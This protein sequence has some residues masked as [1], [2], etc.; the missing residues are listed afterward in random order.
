MKNALIGLAV[1]VI[2]A[3]AGG[4]WYVYSN[5][6]GLVK[7]AIE[8]YGSRATKTDVRVTGVSISLGE[9]SATITG[10]S[11]A[12]PAG[13]T[14][15]NA[16]TLATATV[17]LDTGALT[18]EPYGIDVINVEG[19]EIFFEMNEAGED[20]LR[21]LRDNLGTAPESGSSDPSQPSPRLAIGRIS[22]AE[23]K[24]HASLAALDE[25][26]EVTMPSLS[27]TNLEGEPPEIA[28]QI[29]DQLID[30]ALAAA[31]EEGISRLR[32]GALEKLGEKLGVDKE[33]VDKLKDRFGF[34]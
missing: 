12:N 26:R 14:Y 23:A 32:E 25:T 3:I 10:L 24:L 29:A 4:A 17:D 2:L 30:A 16:F 27:M 28:R 34:D 9:G 7:D 8:Y 6:D 19:P 20:N 11:V 5:L 18:A 15:P 13:F 1:V 31:R 33:S 21:T 22:L